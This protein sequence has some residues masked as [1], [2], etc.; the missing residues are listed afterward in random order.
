MVPQTKH[1]ETKETNERNGNTMKRQMH[2]ISIFFL[3][4]DNS[5]A[6]LL[7]PSTAPTKVI[8]SPCVISQSNSNSKLEPCNKSRQRTSTHKNSP[9]P[10]RSNHAVPFVLM[11]SGK[12]PKSKTPGRQFEEN[13]TRNSQPLIMTVLGS[14]TV[15][16]AVVAAAATAVAVAAVLMGR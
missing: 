12:K 4:K 1:D 11:R 14:V 10:R 16:A 5:L 13:A 15:T 7:A 9:R 2:D 6:R 3:R 8:Q